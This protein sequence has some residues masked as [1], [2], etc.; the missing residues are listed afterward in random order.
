M[1]NVQGAATT[2]TDL[3]GSALGGIEMV[4]ECHQEASLRK[5]APVSLRDRAAGRPDRLVHPARR[6][7]A[8]LVGADIP[9]LEELAHLEI[10]GR[11]VAEI[12]EDHRLVATANHD[13]PT[14][15]N[16]ALSH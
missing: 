9:L 1:P 14:W 5:V 13:Q 8:L 7:G 3:A 15:V 10:R 2:V 16:S 4:G 12:I 6:I 11:A